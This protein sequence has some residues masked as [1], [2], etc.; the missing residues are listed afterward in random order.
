M[1]KK[2]IVLG[3]LFFNLLLIAFIFVDSFIIKSQKSIKEGKKQEI[4]TKPELVLNKDVPTQI[5]NTAKKNNLDIMVEYYNE[6]GNADYYYIYNNPSSWNLDVQGGIIK[7]G[8]VYS[9]KPENGE[10][11]IY[12]FFYKEMV[13]RL[14]PYEKIYEIQDINLSSIVIWVDSKYAPIYEKMLGRMGYKKSYDKLELYPEH[15]S[16]KVFLAVMTLFFYLSV[17]IYIFSRNAEYAICYSEGFSGVDV[18]K[19]EIKELLVPSVFVSLSALITVLLILIIRYDLFSVFCFIKNNVLGLLLFFV[20]YIIIFALAVFHVYNKVG[21]LDIKGKQLNR[22]LIVISSILKVV[23]MII[24]CVQVSEIIRISV[25]L[26]EDIKIYKD[27][28]KMTSGITK[29]YISNGRLDNNT[30][31]IAKRYLDFLEDTDDLFVAE[32]HSI[33]NIEEHSVPDEELR[34]LLSPEEYNER[35]IREKN[36]LYS[37]TITKEYLDRNEIF[38]PDG[39]RLTKEHID[40][41][42][43]NFLVP[44]GFNYSWIKNELEKEY[45]KNLNFIYYSKDNS[46]FSFNPDINKSTSGYEKNLMVEVVN[47]R[48]YRNLLD[49]DD[50]LFTNLVIDMLGNTYYIKNNN[51]SSAYEQIYE[52]LVKHDLTIEIVELTALDQV[53]YSN[54][55]DSVMRMINNIIYTVIYCVCYLILL[56][57]SINLLVEN[58]LKE[59]VVKIREGYSFINICWLYIFLLAYQ[60]PVLLLFSRKMF[61]N[62]WLSF[63]IVGLDVF[64]FI[65]IAKRVI[66]RK[67]LAKLDGV[68]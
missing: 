57:Y 53:Y 65:L 41:D 13:E 66:N 12:G 60:I 37:A 47:P 62:M 36:T 39:N 49:G 20:V 58:H 63:A 55:K 23:A 29:I 11:R 34:R 24:I 68:R 5:Y 64:L 16:I 19:Q 38:L 33:D 7:D 22:R 10:L 42:K 51:D 50:G 45:G 26:N 48:L 43:I 67:N 14:L 1:K 2:T 27:S 18:L 30:L 35:K 61:F 8:N 31:Y 25:G 44:D 6:K 3:L 32:F 9:T 52:K 15:N 4:F 21:I 54:I 17:L 56:F 40:D 28:Q 59:I 46:F